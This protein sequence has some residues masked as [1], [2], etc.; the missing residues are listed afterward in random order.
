M[1]ATSPASLPGFR[2]ARVAATEDPQRLVYVALHNDYSEEFESTTD[3]SEEQCGRIAVSRLLKSNRGHYGCYSADTSVMTKRGW[4]LW[5]DVK[6]D[7]ML[8]A[9][10]HE[11]GEASFE[12]PIKLIRQE[13]EEGDCLYQ[14]SSQRL[15]LLVT[16]DHRMVASH[17]RPSNSSSPWSEWYF[18]QAWRVAG[19]A[20]RY[21]TAVELGDEDRS[22]PADM[23]RSAFA[24]DIMRIA[25]FY[26]G[27]GV[28]SHSIN[29]RVLRFRLRRGRK[30]NYLEANG[31]SVG[32]LEPKADDRFTLHCGEVAS[33]VER[34]F[35]GSSGK[36]VPDWILSLPRA[37]FVAFLDGLKNSDGTNVRLNEDGSDYSWSFDSSELQALELIQAAAAINGIG[38]NLTLNNPNIGPGHENHRPFWRLTLSHCRQTARFEANQKGRTRGTEAVVP[39]KGYVYCATVSTGALLVRRNGKPVVSGNCLEHPQ[40]SLLLRA[41]HN[42]M[43]QL[44]THRIGASYD[45]QSMRYTGE[46]M[47]KVAKGEVPTEHVFYVR[48]PGR[49]HDR[50]GDPYDWSEDDWRDQL[51]SS[52]ASA[53][54]YAMLRERG[55]SEEHARFA[56]TTN[57]Y[58][59]MLVSGNLRYWLHLLD[60]RSK[61]DA[62]L[63]IQVL[64]H[65]VA[66]HIEN[67]APEIYAWYASHRLGKAILA[68]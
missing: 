34:H 63:E 60:V 30:I 20:V 19:R 7:D 1:P 48:P 46:R 28:R 11:T 5:P 18:E 17:R 22:L 56:L 55:V 68:P 64:M 62:Q 58:Q 12:K 52:G 67:W 15:D 32:I 57:Y 24:V 41:D 50:Q 61:A 3:L 33:W 53:T 51:L 9:V 49:Y 39:Y 16:H 36:T 42:T 25:G 23:P 45:C 4:V 66:S 6:D 2:C 14:A 10:N 13:L 8:L 29:P 26:F 40:L 37:E 65:M 47:I 54:E 35:R 43:V 27:D 21:M 31:S 38:T 44:R 59:N